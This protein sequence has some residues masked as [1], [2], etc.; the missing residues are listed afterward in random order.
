MARRTRTPTPQPPPVLTTSLA[1]AER[2]VDE[3]IAKGRELISTDIDNWE[4][5]K[6]ARAKYYTWTEYVTELLRRIFSTSEI[7]DEFKRAVRMIYSVGGQ[8]VLGDETQEFKSDAGVHV[9]RLE[10]VRERLPLYAGEGDQ[11]TESRGSDAGAERR[12]FIVHGHDRAARDATA[13]L[14]ERLGLEPVILAEQPNQGRTIIEKFEASVDVSFAVILMTPDDIG[15]PA[16]AADRLTP[17]ARQNVVLELGFFIGRL[18][19]HRV[20]ALVAPSVEIPSDI[21]G[22]LYIPYDPAG[23]WELPLAREM[24]SAGLPIDLNRL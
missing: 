7:S 22:I 18:G 8:P 23:A 6:V 5:L 15:A 10:S 12:V 13:R 16:S 24:K 17:R 14:L 1:E 4:A 20:A 11:V 2:L 3:Q 9:R 19:R 21:D